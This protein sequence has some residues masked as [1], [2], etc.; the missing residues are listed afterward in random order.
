VNNN[1]RDILMSFM[2]TATRLLLLTAFL[3]PG[4]TGQ[5][6]KQQLP[7]LKI[8]GNKRFL[9]DEHGEPFFWLGDTGW[10]LFTKLERDEARVYLDNRQ[11]KGY[12][13]IQVML[14]HTVG[15]VNIYGDSALVGMDVSAPL[16]TPGN[17][18]EDPVQYDYWDHVDFIIGQ[19]AERGIYMAL[20]PVWGSNVKQGAVNIRQAENY[21]SWLA[22][23]YGSRT[24]II[25]MNGG[26]VF[27]SDST[28]IWEMIGR[29]LDRPDTI[30]LITFHPRGRMQS[31]MWFH[32]APWLD[33]NMF[34]SGHRRYDQDDTELNYGEDNWRYVRSDYDLVPVKPTIDGEPSYE[35]IPQGLHDTTQPYWN[36]DDVRRYAYWSVFSGSFGHTYGHNDVMQMHRP[37][38]TVTDFGPRDYWFNSIDAPGAG[39]MIHLKNL[40]LS[41]PFFERYP[42]QS[43]IAGE[44]GERY[45]YQAATRGENY[46]LIYTWNGRN[47]KVNMQAL[48]ADKVKAA[49]YDPRTGKKT[50]LGSYNDPGITEFD[51]PGEPVNGNDWVLVLEGES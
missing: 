23:R 38:D 17:D 34:Q 3:F 11:D 36:D 22:G 13:V 51:P 48:G 14:L 26:D 32:Q 18:P 28:A 39:Q 10:L 9:M 31:S 6:E 19:A 43:L 29:T 20:V 41:K 21:A 16:T 50:P 40:I 12:N 46:A 33:F 42:D 15:D 49:W 25:W 45:D 24:N 35:G 5:Q 30:H 1:N 47:I 4:C 7:V 2:R 8:S 44:Q 37:G 27:G